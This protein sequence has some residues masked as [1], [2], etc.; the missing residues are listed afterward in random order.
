MLH[1]THRH[2]RQEKV[3]LWG[4]STT[5]V[6]LNISLN[7]S[8]KKRETEATSRGRIT[9]RVEPAKAFVSGG[10]RT[11]EGHRKTTNVYITLVFEL[12]LPARLPKVQRVSCCSNKS[13]RTQPSPITGLKVTQKV[14]IISLIS[15]AILET[16]CISV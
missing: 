14:V 11:S 1:L 8:T 2:T 9:V 12:E 6:E 4:R 15:S 13:K 3:C 7:V 16:M 5:S 10:Q